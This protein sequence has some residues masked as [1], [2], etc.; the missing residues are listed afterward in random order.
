MSALQNYLYFY[1]ILPFVMTSLG[2]HDNLCLLSVIVFI[3][4]LLLLWEVTSIPIFR[5]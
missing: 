5:F 4:I 1:K 3:F 2:N